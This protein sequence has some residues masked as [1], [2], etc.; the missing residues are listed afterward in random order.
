MSGAP[1][2]VY[3]WGR[4][5][6]ERLSV[7]ANFAWTMASSIIF[8]TCQWLIIVTLAHSAGS[9]AV[10]R[11][12]FALAVTTPPLLFAANNLRVAL[13][14]D[15]RSEFRFVDYLILRV[16]SLTVATSGIAVL[17]FAL[18][19]TRAAALLIMLVAIAKCFDLISD[20]VYGLLQKYE[21][22]DRIGVSR[23][24]QGI[25]QVF[26]IN[27]AFRLTGSLLSAV[28]VWAVT[29]GVITFSYDL[30][31]TLLAV[32][33]H[34]AEIAWGGARRCATRVRGLFT[35]C[36]PLAGTIVLG[37]LVGSVPVYALEHWRNS[38]EVGVFAAQIR[39]VAAIGLCFAALAD[40]ATPR[41]ARYYAGQQ[42]EFHRLAR[43]LLLIGAGNG[44]FAVVGT[45]L[46]GG[47]LLRLV[48]G[49]QYADVGLAVLLVLAMAGNLVAPAAA[50]SA[51]HRYGILLVA[52][53]AQLV[54][55]G[56]VAVALTGRLG[57]AGAA[58]GLVVG[59]VAYTGLLLVAIRRLLTA[60]PPLAEPVLETSGA[61][62]PPVATAPAPRAEMPL[63]SSVRAS[64]LRSES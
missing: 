43:R 4:T 28:A 5:G 61:P 56:G 57:T 16:V 10:G 14:T 52:G 45:A 32:R 13:A 64:G 59:Q 42:A 63:P 12:A 41:L 3:R 31:S 15:A 37:S 60:Q 25:L 22:M 19:R 62:Q 54:V 23:I 38:G 18:C 17:A 8:Q 33:R 2:R 48:Y 11:F 7:R 9:V 49:P 40:V 44:L 35:K 53:V 46:A 51:A 27:V 20:T 34:P 39:L 21:R 24:I 50:A 36:L 47:M 26:A 6:P 1:R 55:T 58:T 30:R 29:S